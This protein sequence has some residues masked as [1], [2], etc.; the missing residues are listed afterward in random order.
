[1]APCCDCLASQAVLTGLE[2]RPARTAPDRGRIV[3]MLGS[4]EKQE[5]AGI[6]L[7]SF[8]RVGAPIPAT[9]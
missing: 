9:R 6:R 2:S 7:L 8:R 1:M 3:P 4:A 5:V